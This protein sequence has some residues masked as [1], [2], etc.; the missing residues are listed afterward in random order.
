MCVWKLYIKPL[1]HWMVYYVLDFLWS[2]LD[3]LDL[4]EFYESIFWVKD[5]IQMI[6]VVYLYVH[7]NFKK[8]MG[9]IKQSSFYE[10]Q[11]T[12]RWSHDTVKNE[13]HTRFEMVTYFWN[14]IFQRFHY[15]SKSLSKKWK[16]VRVYRNNTIIIF[17]EVF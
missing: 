2:W 5:D 8:T 3:L 12:L 14:T 11:L 9:S 7:D 1:Q 13:K 17:V 16:N 4:L 15:Y 10:R 6:H